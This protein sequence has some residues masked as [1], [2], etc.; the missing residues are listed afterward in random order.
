MCFVACTVNDGLVA[1]EK[2][3]RIEVAGGGTAEVAVPAELVQNNKL[4]AFRI[5]RQDET[6][7]IEFPRETSTGKWRAWV[8]T[9][10]VSDVP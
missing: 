9:T 8:R 10:L 2:F 5:G 3:V 7:L 6:T 4:K 1:G